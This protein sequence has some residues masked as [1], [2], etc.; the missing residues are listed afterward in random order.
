MGST[1]GLEKIKDKSDS[2]YTMVSQDLMERTNQTG[3]NS[4]KLM[5]EFMNGYRPNIPPFVPS[6]IAELIQSCWDHDPS[7]RPTFTEILTFL[8]HR[9]ERD[10]LSASE[11]ISWTQDQK[12]EMRRMSLVNAP[13]QMTDSDFK[14]YEIHF[15]HEPNEDKSR[16]SSPGDKPDNSASLFKYVVLTLPSTIINRTESIPP[17]NPEGMAATQ[18]LKSKFHVSYTAPKE[19]SEVLYA[20]MTNLV[21]MV[22][23]A[24]DN[25][26]SAGDTRGINTEN[27][28]VNEWVIFKMKICPIK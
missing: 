16:A 7:L 17:M 26:V 14:G 12:Q 1:I 19:E 5:N 27:P 21:D 3:M 22:N 20:I 24:L 18:L 13:L 10:V 9:V 23:Y 11:Q 15:N 2:L 28:S 8:K 6:S 4:N 25:V